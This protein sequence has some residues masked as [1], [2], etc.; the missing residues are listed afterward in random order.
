MPQHR[1]MNKRSLSIQ[2]QRQTQYLPRLFQRR[3][4][5]NCN[6]ARTRACRCHLDLLV[7]LVD[8]AVHQSHVLARKICCQAPQEH[9]RLEIHIA[10]QQRWQSSGQVSLPARLV[11]KMLR[12]SDL[13]A[14]RKFCTTGLSAATNS[15]TF[16][17][18]SHRTGMH[19]NRSAPLTYPRTGRVKSHSA[20]FDQ[21]LE[22]T[23]S[24]IPLFILFLCHNAP[25]PCKTRHVEHV[26][27][28]RVRPQELVGH[29]HLAENV[30][31]KSSLRGTST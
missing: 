7:N 8:N 2:R 11:D 12:K 27:P 26:T 29:E 6:A 30:Q 24:R 1:H 28:F 25:R 5:T 17:T 13:H 15:K 10:L 31:Q 18:M 14:T 19:T 23:A 9:E 3:R 22:P 20:F 4:I 21:D 16:S